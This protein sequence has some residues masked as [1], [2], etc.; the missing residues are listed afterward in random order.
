[1]PNQL[2][3]PGEWSH[4]SDLDSARKVAC[5][6]VE[7]VWSVREWA[8]RNPDANDETEEE[9]D[10]QAH[11]QVRGLYGGFCELDYYLRQFGEAFARA[12][13]HIESFG[14]VAAPSYHETAFWL[15]VTVL[16]AS[17]VARNR[18]G[19]L[20][21]KPG[22]MGRRT[23]LTSKLRLIK[24]DPYKARFKKLIRAWIPSFNGRHLRSWIAKES[25]QARE[26]AGQVERDRRPLDSESRPDTLF[27]LVEAVLWVEGVE[28]DFDQ[29]AARIGREVEGV[30]EDYDAGHKLLQK[31]FELLKS[32]ARPESVGTTTP[33]SPRLEEVANRP[34]VEQAVKLEISTWAALAIG[35]DEN[36]GYLAVSPVP[37]NGAV[38]PR[39]KSLPLDLPGNRWKELL[40]ALS[41]SEDGKT[42]IKKD[43][44]VK[45]GYISRIPKDE[46]LEDLR[47]D[48]G[49]VNQIKTVA[50]RLA[51]AIGDL[52]RE[53]R[54][55][56]HA[57]DDKPRTNL[58]MSASD[59]KLIL[60]NF[61]TRHLQRDA[62]SKLRFG[63][64]KKT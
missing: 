35:I 19:M 60:A 32:L 5:Y 64:S 34:I 57:E 55:Q 27:R 52:N 51:T 29:A 17:E 25:A 14:G 62:G 21:S 3:A 59:S 24:K 8:E 58:P 23:Y 38:F 16:H 40:E 54:K 45:F 63:A 46:E 15:A 10:R 42:A 28:G 33:S 9:L 7:R 48:Q 2:P 6:I 1:M 11:I 56:V 44:F 18:S 31:V 13:T 4:S 53:L 50:H 36:G 12:L 43:L 41:T 20:V 49:Q 30:K 39:E 37:D 22:Q 47:D 26:L 61:T